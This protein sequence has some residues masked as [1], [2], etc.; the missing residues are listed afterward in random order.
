MGERKSEIDVS[1]K[2]RFLSSKGPYL[3]P[4]NQKDQSHI[5]QPLF[6]KKHKCM[7]GFLALAGREGLGVVQEDSS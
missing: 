3:Y 5:K 2:P 7:K 1:E 4:V 6:S